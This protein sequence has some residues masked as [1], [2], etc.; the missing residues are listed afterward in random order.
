MSN[1]I[2][3]RSPIEKIMRDALIERQIKFKEEVSLYI[4]NK[5]VPNYRIDFVAYGKVCK[6]AIECDGKKYHSTLKQQGHDARKNLLIIQNGYDNILRF[7]G[8]KIYH[9]VSECID[10]IEKNISI[11]DTNKIKQ[12]ERKE[13]DVRKIREKQ[14]NVEEVL[15]TITLFKKEVELAYKSSYIKGVGVTHKN[16][17]KDLKRKLLKNVAVNEQM[18]YFPYTNLKTLLEKHTIDFHFLAYNQIYVVNLLMDNKRKICLPEI[19]INDNKIVKI[20]MTPKPDYLEKESTISLMKNWIIINAKTGCIT[21][22]DFLEIQ[23]YKVIPKPSV[24]EIRY[25]NNLM[26]PKQHHIEDTINLGDKSLTELRTIALEIGN[27]GKDSYLLSQLFIHSDYEVRRRACSAAAK[28]RNK[29]IVVD[30]VPCLYAKEPQVR[31]YALK[32]VWE[33]KCSLLNAHIVEV[34]EKEDKEYNIKLCQRILEQ[35]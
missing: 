5:L 27:T 29:D 23:E 17:L 26:I 6:I 35:L 16:L 4:D 8:E 2:D 11:Y 32:A 19:L 24:S 34:L 22:S 33:S 10:E 7:T 13:I 14:I 9:N 18:V 21:K 1:I 28:L 30:I 20:F 31:Q 3:L 15:D 12:I 25:N